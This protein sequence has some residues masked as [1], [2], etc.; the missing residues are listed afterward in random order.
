MLFILPGTDRGDVILT[1]LAGPNIRRS[2]QRAPRGATPRDKKERERK[3]K[4][5]RG[6]VRKSKRWKEEKC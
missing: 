2:K 4:R 5:E 6:M 3:R 1:H